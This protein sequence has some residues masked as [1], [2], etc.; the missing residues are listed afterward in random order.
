MINGIAK[1]AQIDYPMPI[2]LGN[3]DEYTILEL[4]KLVKQLCPSKSEYKFLP[5]PENDPKK[6]KPDISKAKEL[7]DWEPKISLEQG[8]KKVIEWFRRKK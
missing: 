8:L 1:V 4:A 7:L 5:L 3:A 6:R 2:N